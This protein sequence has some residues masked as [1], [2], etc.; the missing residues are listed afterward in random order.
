VACWD[1]WLTAFEACEIPRKA[2][3][4][5]DGGKPVQ[6][7]RRHRAGRDMAEH[8][9]DW[10]IDGK[11]RKPARIAVT[12]IAVSGDVHCLRAYAHC[13]CSGARKGH[14]ATHICCAIAAFSCGESEIRTSYASLKLI[15]VE[16]RCVP[17]NRPSPERCT[18]PAEPGAP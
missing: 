12:L 14:F 18:M 10:M 17:P 11:K 9:R 13:E 8:F 7:S 5:E 15:T 4:V 1:L 6:M 16:K 3:S 2:Y